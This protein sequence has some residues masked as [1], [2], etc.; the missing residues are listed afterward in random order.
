VYR[1][2]HFRKGILPLLVVL[3]LTF[4]ASQ[5]ACGQLP[6]SERIPAIGDSP[7]DAG[8][9]AKDLSPVFRKKDV[10]HALGKVAD[11][12]LKRVEGNYEQD[13]T[14]A[15]LYAGFMAVPQAVN[16]AKYQDAM[17]SMGKQF[18]WQLGN[19]PEHADDH[20]V[21]QTYLE[22][23]ETKHDPAM[24]VPTR[25]SMDA[26]LARSDDPK[27]P[28]WWWCDALFMAPPVLAKLSKD[29]GDRK[30]IDFMNREW[31]I[32][33][34]L[35]YDS[36]LHLYSRDASFLDK[37]EANGKKL[38]WA[39]G[40]GWVMAGLARV[41]EVM[42]DSYPD[43]AR[44]VTQY[45]EMAKAIAA[46]QGSDGLWRPG[47]LDATAYP[48][49]EVSGSA[50][51]TYAL[52]WGVRTGLL[53]RKEYLPVVQ[54]AWAGLLTHIYADGR[55]GCIQPIGASP[56]KFTVTSSYVYGVGAFLL[57]GSEV[58]QLSEPKRMRE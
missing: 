35:L 23:Y 12:Q 52:A 5:N 9:L 50:F 57:A 15:A 1:S 18:S 25:Q 37:K 11:W 46:L 4:T 34:S 54:K 8:P 39:R 21:G 10:A 27:K 41:L 48:L 30:Y 42:P 55:L 45:R 44:Y 49:P 51:N 58:Y 2:M 31:W 17:L 38:F 24:V 6:A 7:A 40:N 13:W 29:A 19:R 26:L 28:L 33:S 32:T 36:Q 3:G 14:M 53:D 16:G 56:D 47:L 22:L 43:R 20:A